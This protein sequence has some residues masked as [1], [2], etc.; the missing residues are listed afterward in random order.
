MRDGLFLFHLIP[1]AIVLAERAESPS[2]E[3]RRVTMH[4]AISWECSTNQRVTMLSV[5]KRL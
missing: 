5:C 1:S 3:E 4:A 2:P